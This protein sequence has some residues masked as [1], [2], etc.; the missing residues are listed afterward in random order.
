MGE[1]PE[2][3]GE[4]EEGEKEEIVPGGHEE[5]GTGLVIFRLL[6]GRG[7]CGGVVAEKKINSSV[8]GARTRNLWLIRPTH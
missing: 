1:L 5:V 2:G 6:K 7:G 8:T 3:E 4:A